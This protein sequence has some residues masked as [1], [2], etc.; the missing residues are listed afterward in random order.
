MKKKAKKKGPSFQFYPD[1]WLSSADITMMTPAEEGA[2]IRLLCYA[3][4][5]DDC[6]IPAEDKHLARLSRLNENW[7]ESSEIIR[8][9]FEKFEGRLFNIK[10]LE[11]RK[12]YDD[13]LKKS[14]KGGEKSA[15]V[16]KNAIKSGS[17]EDK[18]GCGLVQ[19]KRQPS[20][21]KTD[22][23]TRKKKEPKGNT[24]TLSLS[25]P[26][27]LPLTLSLF[28]SLFLSLS[29]PL[30]NINGDNASQADLK[31]KTPAKN[32]VNPEVKLFFDWWSE[33]Y[34][35]AKGAAYIFNG[36]KEGTLIKNLLQVWKL[37]ELK[38]GA[39]EFLNIDDEF[40]EEK[41]GYTIAMYYQKIN[42]IMQKTSPLKSGISATT[43]KN[44]SNLNEWVSG[45]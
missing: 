18:N 7:Q 5:S 42:Q 38:A 8:K 36:G 19:T 2:Y 20:A 12:S 13:W 14:K 16:R 24:L 35:A 40:L 22:N 23:Q 6:S 37:E 3:W 21:N 4:L 28:P 32:A 10:L 25:F 9:K 39:A 29:P 11:A 27:S 26:L 17:T 34:K 33:A 31:P 1:A 15:E 45:E 41:T 43:K 30:N 44:I